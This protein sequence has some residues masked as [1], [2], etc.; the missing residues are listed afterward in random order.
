MNTKKVRRNDPCPCGSG[1]KT[2][3]CHLQEIKEFRHQIGRGERLESL[4][5]EKMLGKPSEPETQP[6]PAPSQ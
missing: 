3:N 4:L 2:K 5:V 6:D 1:R